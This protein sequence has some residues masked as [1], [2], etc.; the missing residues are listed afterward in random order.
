MGVP[1]VQYGPTVLITTLTDLTA[2]STSSK[3]VTFTCRTPTL[4]WSGAR[5]PEDFRES[6]VTRASSFDFERAARENVK[7]GR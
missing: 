1:N 3:L 2:A 7:E 4:V 6:S 5:A